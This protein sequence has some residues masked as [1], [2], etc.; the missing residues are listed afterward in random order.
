MTFEEFFIRKKID[1]DQ[2]QKGDPALYAEFKSHFAVMGEKSF[3]HS[4]KFWFNKLRHLYHL[5]ESPKGLTQLETKIASQAEGLPSPSMEQATAPATAEMRTPVS[6][7]AGYKP[8]FKTPTKEN[9]LQVSEESRRSGS[10]EAGNPQ[11]STPRPTAKKPPFKPRNIPAKENA[12][13]ATT[14][15][16]RPGTNQA[17]E[18]SVT[19]SGSAQTS[20]SKPAYKP[21]FNIHTLPKNPSGAA[22]QTGNAA[23][24]R[25]AEEPQPTPPSTDNPEE[26]TARNE[27]SGTEEDMSAESKPKPAY[28]PRFNARNIKPKNNP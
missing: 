11:E 26:E 28:K 23:E 3:D 13:D 9:P 25:P 6:K 12:A 16:S 22:E 10:V 17:P 2:L 4:K 20:S 7:P 27:K 15:D 8:R 14:T 1:L 18:P 24:N 19:P 5:N 21:R